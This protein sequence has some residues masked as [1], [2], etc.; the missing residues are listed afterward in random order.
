M[1]QPV[2]LRWARAIPL[3][4]YRSLVLVGLT[5]MPVAVAAA[6]GFGG[7]LFTLGWSAR[8]TSP[9]IVKVLATVGELA[10]AGVWVAV[11]SWFMLLLTSRPLSK[12]ARRCARRWL[13]LP[14]EVSYRPAPTIIRMATGYWWNGYEYEKSE[15]EARRRGR[16]LSR[17]KD[18]QLRRDVIWFLVAAVT[19]VP[20]AA[21]PWLG[22]AG[23]VYLAV[24]PGALGYGIGV[25]VAS[26]VIA[27]FAWRI[28]GPVASR[29]LGP[30]PQAR[31]DKRVEE[32]ASIRADLTHTQAAE[33]ERIER[34]LHDGAQARLVALGVSMGAAEHLVD[35][36]PE[37]AKA[38]L[39]EARA[40]SV[41]ALTE[42]RSLV[43]GINPPVLSERGLV[44]AVRG[45]G[46]RRSHGGHR[47]QHRNVP[48]GTT[49]GVGGLFRRR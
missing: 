45:A 38:I 12:A 49:G 32:L 39:A 43:R 31:L 30:P 47:A 13:A 18:P 33:L 20:V 1:S 36:D 46:A 26:L 42:L 17:A 3:G 9:L 6:V 19:V 15:R 41:A 40:S 21:L 10:V 44:D 48:A 28:L 35:A 4:F 2:I 27:P 25:L 23:G 5:V 8:L 34:G 22:L 14:I 11:A 29:F 37:A 16:I 7:S 24:T